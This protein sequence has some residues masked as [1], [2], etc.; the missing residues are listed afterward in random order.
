MQSVFI[1][2]E[3]IGKFS[4]NA[5]L[6]TLI[7]IR[8]YKYDVPVGRHKISNITSGFRSTQNNLIQK[9]N[10]NVWVDLSLTVWLVVI[11]RVWLASIL[12][13]WLESLYLAFVRE[14]VLE[15]LSLPL[16]PHPRS[17]LPLQVPLLAPSPARFK[18][19]SNFKI[20]PMIFLFFFCLQCSY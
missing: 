19:R 9:M 1:N 13:V 15:R 14:G 20:L 18:K 7:V 4:M 10:L 2:N 5:Y 8:G 3:G 17:P 12:R 6:H 11:L 16:P